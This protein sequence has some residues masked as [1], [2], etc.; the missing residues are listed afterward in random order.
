MELYT[1]T[2]NLA[3]NKGCMSYEVSANSPEGARSIADG[4]FKIEG[5][6]YTAKKVIVK[7]GGFQ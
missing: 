1:V 2:Y 6:G 7:K 4:Y 5:V 3:K